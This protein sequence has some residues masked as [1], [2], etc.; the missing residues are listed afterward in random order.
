MKIILQ[1]DL[2]ASFFQ[3]YL[4]VKAKEKESLI[5]EWLLLYRANYG[6]FFSLK[7]SAKSTS[8]IRA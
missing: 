3:E 4:C 1:F 5:S 7:I 2:Y 8:T 6:Y